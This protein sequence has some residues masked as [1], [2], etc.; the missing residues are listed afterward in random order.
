[1][2]NSAIQHKRQYDWLK[3]YQWQKGQS[4][5]PKGGPRGKRLKTFAA[6]LLQE[7]EGDDKANFLKTLDPEIV[8]RMAEGNPHSTADVV[9]RNISEV[10]NELENVNKATRQA[11]ENDQPLQDTGQTETPD[12]VPAQP[13][14]DPL[15]TAQ[16][17]TE[18]YT[19]E[20]PTGIHN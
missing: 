4:G 5:N 16:M 7:M 18:H 10:L 13:S 2:Q 15:P 8:W 20:P 3:Q 17:V 1:M 19:E 14:A 11:M 12:T 9:T 6:E